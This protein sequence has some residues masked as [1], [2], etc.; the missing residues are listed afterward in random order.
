MTG[1]RPFLIA[2]AAGIV[3][4][5]AA[6]FLEARLGFGPDWI[7]DAILSA[8]FLTTTYLW[9]DL[10]AT[11]TRLSDLERS[12][13][14]L[15]SQLTLAAEIQRNL[16]PPVPRPRAGCRWGALMHPAGKIGGD[17]YDF[18]ETDRS[19][20]FILGDV[21]GKGIPAALLMTSSR[22]IF[23]AIGRE[24]HDPAEVLRRLSE[25]IFEDNKGAPYL[26]CVAARLDF[27]ERRLT[28]VNAGHPPSLVLGVGGERRLEA[29][30]PPAGMFPGARYETETV[31]LS[32]GDVLVAVSDGITEALENEGRRFGEALDAA[33][34]E[35]GKPPLPERFCSLLM[36]ASEHGLDRGS[37]WHDDR[38]IVSVAIEGS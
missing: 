1:W 2:V 21:S 29:G 24:T 25:V 35:A 18:L 26:T 11:R 31:A 10:R 33:L 5:L 38:T 7:S 23:R 34:A 12:Q 20:L 9:L 22:A 13:I 4:P 15:E 14:A 28:H 16:L 36:K 19:V 3:A 27:R 30:G 6:M 37:G 17:F 32:P 8:A